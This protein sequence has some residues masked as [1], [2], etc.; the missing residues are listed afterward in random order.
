MNDDIGMSCA[1]MV[2]RVCN[3]YPSQHV[4]A[5][6]PSHLHDAAPTLA[7][8]VEVR[9]KNIH[10]HEVMVYISNVEHIDST[11][12]ISRYEHCRAWRILW[13]S[14]EQGMETCGVFGKKACIT[15]TDSD[16]CIAESLNLIQRVSPWFYPWIAPQHDGILLRIVTAF[17]M[18]RLQRKV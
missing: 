7:I 14:E 12:G 3:G 13:S 8:G 2:E 9:D 18:R 15:A 5:V 6:F 1:V 10:A 17:V 11:V 4:G 16:I